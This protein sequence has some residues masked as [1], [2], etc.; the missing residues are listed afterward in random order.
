MSR[1]VVSVAPE[2]SVVTAAR[3][4]TSSRIHRVVVLDGDR[5]CGVLSTLDLVRAVGQGRV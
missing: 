4:M 1:W 2:T 3:L 5:L